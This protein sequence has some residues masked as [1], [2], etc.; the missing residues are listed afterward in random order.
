[1]SEVIQDKDY[2]QERKNVSGVNERKTNRLEDE[3]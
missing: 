3:S 1:M 2:K